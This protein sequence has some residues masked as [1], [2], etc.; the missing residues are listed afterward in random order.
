MFH[1][2]ARALAGLAAIALVPLAC[3][4]ET[5]GGSPAWSYAGPNGPAHWGELDPAFATCATGR[6]QSPI[7]LAAAN[8]E[9]R[10]VVS[11]HYRPVPLTILNNGHNVQFDGSGAGELVSRGTDFGLVQVHFHA[12]AEYSIAGIRRPLDAHFVHKAE[13][14]SLAVLVASFVEGPPNPVLAAMMPYLPEQPADARTFP[15]VTIDPSDLLPSDMSVYRY[16]GSLT[17]PPCTEGVNWYVL[18]APT[19][20]SGE[21]IARFS[22]ILKMN[23]RPVQPLNGRLLVAPPGRSD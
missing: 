10:I 3:A 19:T 11:V 2:A 15:G 14:G 18:K 9:G 4:A 20:A 8:A 1:A 6:M 7:D 23:A 16:M 5:S 21:Q 12:P 22:A 17:T 13:D